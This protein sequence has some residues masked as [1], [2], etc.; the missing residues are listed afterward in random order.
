MSEPWSKDYS[1]M[2]AAFAARRMQTEDEAELMRYLD[3][4]ANHPNGNLKMQHV[5]R[6]RAMTILAIFAN[7][8]LAEERRRNDLAAEANRILARQANAIAAGSF[9][10]AALSLAAVLWR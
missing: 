2:A 1:D 4:L 3:A 10:V 8:R 9:A 6:T 7:R 5:D